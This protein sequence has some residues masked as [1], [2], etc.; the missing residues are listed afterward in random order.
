M[1]RESARGRCDPRVGR[2]SNASRSTG[3]EY[4]CG[5]CVVVTE[6]GS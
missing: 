2:T 1:M 5:K 3:F 4:V 6:E